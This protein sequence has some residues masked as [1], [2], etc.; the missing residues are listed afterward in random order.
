MSAMMAL[1]A[2]LLQSVLTPLVIAAL[3][4]A[5]THPAP[6]PP[7]PV[8]APAA[9]EE[10]GLLPQ[11]PDGDHVSVRPLDRVGGIH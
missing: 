8:E 3:A 10:R 6:P 7:P 1:I 4:L 9:Q 2:A 5:V 11:S